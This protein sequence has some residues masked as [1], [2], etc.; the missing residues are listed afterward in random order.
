VA[1]LKNDTLSSQTESGV[2]EKWL[3][4]ALF[5]A[6]L[7]TSVVLAVKNLAVGVNK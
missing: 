1:W 5:C 2:V 3:P 4:V 6:I 7:K